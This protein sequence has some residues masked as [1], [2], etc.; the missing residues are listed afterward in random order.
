MK[1]TRPI[2]NQPI[3]D[4]AE[5]V[6]KE[7]IFDVYQWQQEMYNGTVRTFEKLKRPDTVIVYGILDTGDI[8]LIEQEQPGNTISK[9]SGCG[10]RI[11]PNEDVLMGAQREFLEESGY[12]ASEYIFWKA[13]QPVTKLDWV[14]Y[15]FVVR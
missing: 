9:V 12:E 13:V 15:F 6:Y 5:C 14:V 1:I 2:S 8:L 10:G 3:P 4:H 11:D 7:S